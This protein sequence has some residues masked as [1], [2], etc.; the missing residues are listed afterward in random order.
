MKECLD[1]GINF[2]ALST[3]ADLSK[4]LPVNEASDGTQAL[5]YLQ[6]HKLEDGSG[7]LIG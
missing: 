3:A 1:P 2:D 6:A 7:R 5:R 4:K